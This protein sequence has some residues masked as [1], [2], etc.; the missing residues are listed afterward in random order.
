M[1]SLIAIY[2]PDTVSLDEWARFKQSIKDMRRSNLTKDFDIFSIVD[3][4]R[5][6]VEIEVF[7]NPYQK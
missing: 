5:E 6:K 1:K 7:F 3:R 4:A 2:I